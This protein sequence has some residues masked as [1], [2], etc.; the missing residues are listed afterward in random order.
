[1]RIVVS[2]GIAASLLCCSTAAFSQNLNTANEYM[3]YIGKQRENISKKFMAYASASAHGK[4]ARKVEHLRTKL[5]NEVEESREN[6]S[7]IASFNGD[8]TYRDS[9]VNFMK[10]YYNILNEDYSKVINTEDIAEQSYDD[11]EAY[12]NLKEAIDRKLDE[13]NDRLRAAEQAF[14]VHNNINLLDDKSEL[15]DM[16]KQVGGLNTYYDVI[17]LIYFKPHIQ[18]ANMMKAMEKGNVTG[19]E[20]T[21]SS[22]LKYANEGLT[23]LATLKGF[24]GDMSLVNTCK[25]VLNFYVKEADKTAAMSDFF[26]GKERFEAIKKE[27]E[28][29]SKHSNEDIDAYNKAVN[30]INKASQAYNSNNGTVNEWRHDAIENWNNAVTGFFDEHTPHYK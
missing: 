18:E 20:Q 1:M 8:K 13:G 24:Q 3:G 11:M 17:Y 7:G 6:I 29:K 14:A 22:M 30:D 19:I 16:I 27:Y 4:K 9:A 28:K 15:G 10:L 23:K 26:L 5:L 25:G 12:I 2:I 21:R